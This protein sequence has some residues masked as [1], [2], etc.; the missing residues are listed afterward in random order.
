MTVPILGSRH[1]GFGSIRRQHTLYASRGQENNEAKL[2]TGSR[3]IVADLAS[4]EINLR[5]R[6]VDVTLPINHRLDISHLV[7][8]NRIC[9]ASG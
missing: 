8:C 7:D 9:N 2:R 1:A 6:R 3:Q 5:R 4:V